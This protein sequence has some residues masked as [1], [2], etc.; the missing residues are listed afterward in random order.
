M[1]TPWWFMHKTLISF[2]LLPFSWI[3]SF[4][5]FINFKIQKRKTYVSKRPIICI[6]NI[7]AGGVGKT[8]IVEQ[9]AKFLDAPVVL[10]GYK[11]TLETDNIGDEALML[12]KHGLSVHTGDRLSN[13]I[14][15]NKQNE[16]TP[17]VMDDGFQNAKYNKD[18]SI[19][20][21]DSVIGIG[22]GF[23]LPAGPLRESMKAV[24]RADAV[25]VIKHGNEKFDLKIPCNIPVFFAKT[26]TSIPEKNNRKKVAFAGIGYPNKFFSSLKNLVDKRSY[27]DHY[28]YTIEDIQNLIVLAKRKKAI[29]VTTEKDFMRIPDF[30]KTSIVCAKLHIEIDKNFYIW[31]QEKINANSKKNN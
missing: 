26:K 24:K 15:L 2:V 5:A 4:V 6:G 10:R 13:I 8:P 27:A 18:V 11:S 3:Y 7:L 28:Q 12:S 22:N 20:V 23:C 19:I 14:L 30:L 31:L 29:L 1:K 16:K 9:I 21:F 17:I 25:I